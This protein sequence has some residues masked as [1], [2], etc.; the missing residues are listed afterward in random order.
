MKLPSG[1]E[2]VIL[3][4]LRSGRE[5]YGL[6]MVKSSGGELKRG[7]IYVLLDRMEDKGF[8]RSSELKEEGWPGMP[9][10]VYEITGLGER[11]LM[12]WEHA[13][14]LMAGDLVPAGAR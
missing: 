9:K 6:E 5:M 7:S 2:L 12:A 13:Q 14:T 1:K 11:A 4:L 3:R 10:R 8:V